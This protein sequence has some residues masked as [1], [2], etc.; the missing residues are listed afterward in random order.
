MNRLSKGK[1]PISW[2]I[3]V[4]LVSI[5]WTCISNWSET[6]TEANLLSV[7]GRTIES[8]VLNIHVYFNTPSCRTAVFSVLRQFTR[9]WSH[10]GHCANLRFN[11]V[12]PGSKSFTP[13]F[14]CL[15]VAVYTT[16]ITAGFS[17]YISYYP[18]QR[19]RAIIN[20]S[21]VYLI[22]S[23]LFLCIHSRA[24]MVLLQMVL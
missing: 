15:C 16:F 11:T 17:K 7:K 3:S 1:F 13:L 19:H 10:R 4:S 22:N 5:Y 6:L 12:T 24:C 21:A 18:N 2:S 14:Y 20:N 23:K 9:I 8:G